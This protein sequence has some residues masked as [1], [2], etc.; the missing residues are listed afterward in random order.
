MDA[1]LNDP[2][3]QASLAPFAVGLVVA[4]VLWPARLGGLAVV[5]AFLTT[6]HLVSGITFSPLTA[7]RKIVL[8]AMAAP[9]VG[10]LV[11]F[12]FKPN[13]LGTLL[14]ALGAA[15][16]VL[17]AFWPV[18]AQKPQAEAL[19][20]GASAAVALA[21]MAGFGQLF[22]GD[23]G[24]RAGAAAL[25]AGIATGA[26]AVIGASAAYGQYAF[27]LA[28]GAGAFLLPQMILGRRCHAGA[29]F[30]LPAMLLAALLAAGVMVLAKLPW[31]ALLALALVPAAARLPVP[32]KAPVWLQAVLLSL[33]CFA[34]GGAACYL[35][36]PKT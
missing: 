10:V 22:L 29:T 23:D 28:A 9:V 19:T 8:L 13:R 11:D 12:A 25:G 32:A 21:F 35:A 31:Y 15:A 26:A 5:A 2:M 33:Y 3:V 16:A 14:L 18:L 27:A 7:T 36:W 20:L 4:G 6:M 34:V 17:W 24:V 30:I 1:W